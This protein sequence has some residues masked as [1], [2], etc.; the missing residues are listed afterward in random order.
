MNG[1]GTDRLTERQNGKTDRQTD[2]QT[3]RPKMSSLTDRQNSRT[4][5]QNCKTPAPLAV[6]DRVNINNTEVR[7]GQHD[8]DS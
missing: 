1:Y 3:D 6:I 8:G 4:G 5:R 2:R 7:R